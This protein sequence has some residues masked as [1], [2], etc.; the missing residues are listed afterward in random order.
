VTAGTD[1]RGRRVRVSATHTPAAA[2]VMHFERFVAIPIP[3][4]RRELVSVVHLLSGE[5]EKW[6]SIGVTMGAKTW[7]VG[8]D[9]V[10][11]V[12]VGL[13]WAHTSAHTP[14]A[15]VTAIGADGAIQGV[16]VVWDRV[17]IG[18]ADDGLLGSARVWV[19]PSAGNVGRTQ[20]LPG[21]SI[22]EV[23]TTR[24]V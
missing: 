3:I 10:V 18:V 15:R 8:T 6:V 11:A 22:L 24:F 9:R 21:V 4:H 13:L 1:T 12:P 17:V 14:A 2:R 7:L 23:T 20:V 5:R 16:H 19:D